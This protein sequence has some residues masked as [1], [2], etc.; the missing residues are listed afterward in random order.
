MAH[1]GDENNTYAISNEINVKVGE[2]VQTTP[3]SPEPS[4]D[5][6]VTGDYIL[7]M[8]CPST[9]YYRDGTEVIFTL[10]KGGVPV[11]GKTIEM[12]DFSYTNTGLTNA[13]GQVSFKNTHATSHPQ[14]WKLGAKFWDGGNKPTK[15]VYKTVTVKKAT[16]E[17]HINHPASNVNGTFSVNLRDKNHIKNK[18]GNRKVTITVNGSKNNRVTNENG[19]EAIKITSKGT[20]KY[21]CTFNGDKDYNKCTLTY[22]EKVK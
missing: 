13:Q 20:Y 22:R 2:P 18:L 5:V 21:V 16:P 14:K 10:T 7:S 1:T 3:P 11:Q 9:M 12:T 6:P 4:H 8:S 19:S 17:F 15:S